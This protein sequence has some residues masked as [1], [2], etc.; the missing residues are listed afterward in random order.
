MIGER[1]CLKDIY[2]DNSWNDLIL[3][4]SEL[5]KFLKAGTLK[6]C[7]IN[8]GESNDFILVPGEQITVV[9]VDPKCPRDRM[10][11]ALR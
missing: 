10:L 4:V 9:S 11:Q 7:Y 3:Q 2:R 1:K 6:S 5:G 8:I